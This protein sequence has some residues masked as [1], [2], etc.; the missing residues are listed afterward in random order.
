MIYFSQLLT[1]WTN[2]K[3]KGDTYLAQRGFSGRKI[4]VMVC[5]CVLVPAHNVLTCSLSI[6]CVESW[7][8]RSS[9][10]SAEF[11]ENERS[12]VALEY[13][14]P[15]PAHVFPSPALPTTTNLETSITRPEV[16]QA[17]NVWKPH[18]QRP[19]PSP[20]ALW[21]HLFP[22]VSGFFCCWLVPYK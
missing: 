17:S 21:P 13:A 19:A 16:I 10:S 15:P 5:V 20:T 11:Q 3:Q 8:S 22:K 9:N 7:S 2:K 4:V 18:E 6:C 12:S 14:P 1:L